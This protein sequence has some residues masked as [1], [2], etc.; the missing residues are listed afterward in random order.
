VTV[1]REYTL[2]LMPR[3]PLAISLRSTI[4]RLATKLDAIEFEPHVTMFC[5]PS[6]DDEARAI[7]HRIANQF[8]PIELIADR[9][10]HSECYTKTFFVQFRDS[11][12][13]RQ[14]F[15][16]T[17]ANFSRQWGYVLNPHLSLLYMRQSATGRQKLC[18]TVDVPT[19]LY[20]FD[21][22]QMIETEL[23]IEDEGPIRRWRVV[24]E[25]PL[26]GS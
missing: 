8:T 9:L 10:E 18:E 13:L 14:M 4:R 26:I 23:P 5:G 24:C 3:E 6:T 7:A 22:I 2:W 21:R 16:V 12:R 15:E 11:A 25:E 20:G 1:C 19:G 17:A